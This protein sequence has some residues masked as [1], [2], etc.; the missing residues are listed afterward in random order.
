MGR[1]REIGEA[2]REEERESESQ[3]QK[4][5]VSERQIDG[6]TEKADR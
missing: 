2:R 1:K 5:R 4:R 3:R 6:Q